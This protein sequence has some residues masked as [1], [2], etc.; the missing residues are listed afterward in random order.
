M[1]YDVRRQPGLP[2]PLAPAMSPSRA[3][4]RSLLTHHKLTTLGG[5][6]RLGTLLWTGLMLIDKGAVGETWIRPVYHRPRHIGSSRET[7]QR[8]TLPHRR[9][10]GPDRVVS[11]PRAAVCRPIYRFCRS[12]KFGEKRADRT[13]HMG[14]ESGIRV[15]QECYKVLVLYCK[16]EASCTAVIP[17]TKPSHGCHRTLSEI[18]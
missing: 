16:C 6:T 7:K 15:Q 8:E 12:L 4:I 1:F 5:E 17:T 9:E 10:S 11:P 3:I 14:V 2:F 18:G 13:G